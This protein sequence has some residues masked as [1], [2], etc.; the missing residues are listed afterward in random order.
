M[1]S[2]SKVIDEPRTVA[3][4]LRELGV[5]PK[6]LRDAILDG[7]A[8]RESCTAHDPVQMPGFLAWGRVVRG[9]RDRLVPDNW[10]A[11]DHRGYATVVSPDESIA[12]A[13]ATGN[14]VTGTAGAGASTKYPKGAAT[15]TAV[16]CNQLE[17]FAPDQPS[18]EKPTTVT[19]LL[20]IRREGDGIHAELSRPELLD[21]KGFVARWSER[22][23]LEL[24]DV[25][26]EPTVEP[27]HD[28]D[29]IEIEV[30]RRTT[31]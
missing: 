8:A 17:L 5:E 10:K 16:E 15:V 31:A 13:V 1:N 19:W 23:L 22:I 20:L 12:I 3:L 28:V 21:T 25:E 26:P 30:T 27:H 6:V 9:L 24:I 4:R 14:E 29:E 7:E 18:V 11:R 2:E